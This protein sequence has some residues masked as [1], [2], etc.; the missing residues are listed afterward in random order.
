MVT[1]YSTK[2]SEATES[3]EERRDHRSCLLNNDQV[4][5]QIVD[6]SRELRGVV[7]LPSTI[8]GLGME[9]V[10]QQSSQGPRWMVKKPLSGPDLRMSAASVVSRSQ[11]CRTLCLQ[12]W[13]ADVQ[14]EGGEPV[15]QGSGHGTVKALASWS[16]G[17]HIRVQAQRPQLPSLCDG[18]PAS[19]TR[20]IS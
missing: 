4:R 5:E 3:R 20:P 11:H 17:Q 18:G 13:S 16:P 7:V 6:L 14:M 12:C 15:A 9:R 19:L 10:Q 2:F 1:L 8:V